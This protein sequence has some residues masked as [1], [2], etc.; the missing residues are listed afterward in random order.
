M[1]GSG[2]GQVQETSQQK[3]LAT[4]A[5]NKLTDY[6]NRWLPVQQHL[7]SQIQAMGQPGSAAQ[8]NAEGR[9][10]T[11]S[12]IKF[13]G[14]QDQLQSNLADSGGLGSS[15]SKLAIAGLGT[16][17]A[18]SKGL[19]MTAADQQIDDAYTQSLGAL[20]AI[21]QGQSAQVGNSLAQQASSSSAQATADAD[22]A[23]TSRMGNAKLIGQ[24]AGYGMQ[25]AMAPSTPKIPALNGPAGSG[26]NMDAGIVPMNNVA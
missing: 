16:D 13:A 18:K 24:F 20:T 10:N 15:R 7:A 2:S 4:Y 3:A 1:A 19:G 11:D 25:S 21:G 12:T 26:V 14:A 23:L 22:A 9:A 5:S 8:K 6:Q 17:E